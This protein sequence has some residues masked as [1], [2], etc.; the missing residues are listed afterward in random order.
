MKNIL[1]PQSKFKPLKS[2]S[3][4]R[5]IEHLVKLS[6]HIAVTKDEPNV[7]WQQKRLIDKIFSIIECNYHI[8]LT[9]KTFLQNI[10]IEYPAIKL[11]PK[12]FKNRLNYRWRKQLIKITLTEEIKK[13]LG[14]TPYIS[15]PMTGYENY[16]SA[17][18][19]RVSFFLSENGL[20]CVNPIVLSK[21]LLKERGH[22]DTD[23]EKI[24]HSEYLDYD[25]DAIHK[26]ATGM[27]MLPGWQKSKGAC[28][29]YQVAIEKSF[30]VY[31][32]NH[33]LSTITLL[34]A[35]EE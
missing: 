3:S 33:E 11:L 30:W 14:C 25:I 2:R 29:E 21:E 7:A 12:S 8:G 27:L 31:E 35:P 19:N 23:Y 1:N 9:H 18:F 20:D 16:N 10:E 13:H 34:H 24:S 4:N 15:G 17:C 26:R 22:S 28:M 32:F 6:L 5:Q